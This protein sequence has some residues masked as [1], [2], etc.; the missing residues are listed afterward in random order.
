MKRQKKLNEQ[1]VILS[2]FFF[3]FYFLALLFSKNGDQKAWAR[4][5]AMPITLNKPTKCHQRVL[6]HI[7]FVQPLADPRRF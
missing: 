5:Y 6:K 1:N 4:L 3:F 7:N 2:F